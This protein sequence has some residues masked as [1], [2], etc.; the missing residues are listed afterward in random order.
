MVSAQIALSWGLATT[1][2]AIEKNRF[3]RAQALATRSAAELECSAAG[4][5]DQS[6]PKVRGVT[7][8]LPASMSAT[9]TNGKPTVMDSL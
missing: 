3:G 5:I 2:Q 4:R 9:L 1:G 7:T 6:A 8:T